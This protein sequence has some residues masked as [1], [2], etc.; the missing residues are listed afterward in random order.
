MLNLDDNELLC[1]VGPGTPMGELLR[2]Y[3]HPV[4]LSEELPSPDCP[5]VRT[6][7]MHEELVAFRDTNG[8]VGL[9]DSHCPHRRA[10]LFFGRNEECGLRCV[11]HGWK[12]DVNGNCVDMPSEP[13]ESNFKDKVKITAYPT[14]ESA[15][16]IWAYMGPVDQEPPF[17]NLAMHTVPPEHVVV[18]KNVSYCN[19]LQGVEGHIDSA[20]IA[21]LHR[22]VGDDAPVSD[23]GTDKPGHLSQALFRYFTSK[24]KAPELQ[25]E[26]TPYGF[27]YAGIRPTD[28]GNQWVRITKHALPLTFFVADANPDTASSCFITVPVDDESFMRYAVRCR[29]DR[30][31][32][33]EERQAAAAAR[34]V[35]DENG[36][37]LRTPF[38]DY[39]IDREAQRTTSITGIIGI[40]NQDFAVTE[41]MGAVCDREREHLGTSDAAIIFLRRMLLKALR[42]LQEGED[43]P[44]LDSNIPFDKIRSEDIVILPGDD[45]RSLASEDLQLTRS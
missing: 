35:N 21:M 3:W 13:A 22:N 10:S 28:N 7:V 18:N 33:P 41:S 38:N 14:R 32:T 29:L 26:E 37:R 9:L 4:L 36:N 45:W 34:A 43:P 15:G 30:P 16:M 44:G 40:P 5:P 31:F 27:R 6:K 12:F 19:Y 24:Y 8:N 25:V 23:D 2:R 20:H 17:Q 42:G 11:Y 1:R 39:L